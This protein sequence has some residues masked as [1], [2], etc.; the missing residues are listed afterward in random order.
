MTY[1]QRIK[2]IVLNLMKIAGALLI[3]SDPSWGYLVIILILSV[4]MTFMGIKG[5]VYY[6]TMARFMVDGRGIFYKG[7]ILLDFGILAGT[8]T[9]VPQYYIFLYLIAIHAFS[10]LVEILRA[11]EEKEYQSRLWIM[12]GMHGLIDFFIAVACIVFIRYPDIAVLI[13]CIG[14]IYSAVTSILY[15]FRK[16]RFVYIQ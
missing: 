10:G 2:E 1:F 16:T 13:Y 11:R 14:V 12:K 15:A 3:M 6:F 7:V 5:L 8:L 9:D 4:V